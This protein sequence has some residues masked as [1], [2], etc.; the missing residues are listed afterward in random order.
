MV[1]VV[2][3]GSW[4]TQQ[5]GHDWHLVGWWGVGLQGTPDW[6]HSLWSPTQGRTVCLKNHLALHREAN[7]RWR[8]TTVF[9]QVK[10]RTNL[11]TSPTLSIPTQSLSSLNL[12]YLAIVRIRGAKAR[13]PT[14][15]RPPYLGTSVWIE[16][17][18]SRSMSKP[19]RLASK[20]M[21][22]S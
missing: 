20:E 15:R 14:R 5:L 21:R 7:P 8:E 13:L 17:P 6:L 4:I 18:S 16:H 2:G 10:R 1:V 11:T 3:R 22:H 19:C 12:W 9:L